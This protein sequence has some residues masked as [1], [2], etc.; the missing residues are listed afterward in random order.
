MG[1]DGEIVMAHMTAKIGLQSNSCFSEQ[2]MEATN[3]CG[4]SVWNHRINKVEIISKIVSS[5]R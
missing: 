3:G 4:E 2:E 5:N 1:N